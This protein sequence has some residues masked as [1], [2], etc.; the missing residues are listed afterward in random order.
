MLSY[1]GSDFLFIFRCFTF[2]CSEVTLTEIPSSHTLYFV[3]SK[4]NTSVFTLKPGEVTYPWEPSCT[5]ARKVETNCQLIFNKNIYDNFCFENV[6]GT[7]SLFFF[8]SWQGSVAIPSVFKV[9]ALKIPK[10]LPPLCGTSTMHHTLG[11]LSAC[12]GVDTWAAGQLD[13][14]IIASGSRLICDKSSSWP[15]YQLKEESSPNSGWLDI[16]FLTA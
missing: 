2:R 3:H 13:T 12:A 6:C 7:Y 11:G 10:L 8:Q 1:D 15:W 16:R 9:V 14:I 5:D 4:H